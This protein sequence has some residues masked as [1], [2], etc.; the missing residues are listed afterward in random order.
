[1]GKKFYSR[2]LGWAE[3]LEVSEKRE[4]KMKTKTTKLVP[5]PFWKMNG[6]QEKGGEGN[7]MCL[8]LRGKNPEIDAESRKKKRKKTLQKRSIVCP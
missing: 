6:Q 1:V 5:V 7:R 4:G 8:P 2:E 3:R